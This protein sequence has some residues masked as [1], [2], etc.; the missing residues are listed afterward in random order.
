MKWL[1][2]SRKS[3]HLEA[4]GQAAVRQA[5]EQWRSA[6]EADE[7][8]DD[9]VRARILEQAY[10]PAKPSMQPLSPLFLPF[11]SMALAGALPALLL[12]IVLGYLPYS[13]SPVHSEQVAHAGSP[14]LRAAKLTAAKVEGEVLFEIANGGRLHRIYRRNGE[15]SHARWELHATASG[16][17]RDELQSG[18][19]L[20]IYRIE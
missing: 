20:V 10:Q 12:A 19:T 14:G 7:R 13:S 11:R 16:S 3:Q 18:D 8:L 15:G 2:K 5:L 6:G 1:Y 17:F 9:G 4:A